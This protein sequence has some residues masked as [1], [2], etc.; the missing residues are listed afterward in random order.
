MT[1]QEALNH[2]RPLIV[3]DI[4]GMAEKVRHGENGFQFR[5]RSAQS[6]ADAIETAASL[7][8][9]AYLAMSAACSAAEQ[10]RTAADKNLSVLR[11]R[12]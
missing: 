10:L 11:A 12:L 5:A 6:L 4:G 3:A 8:E 9:E 7:P 1:I 2:G